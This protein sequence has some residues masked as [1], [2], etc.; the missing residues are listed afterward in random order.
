MLSYLTRLSCLTLLTLLLCRAMPP[1]AAADSEPSGAAPDGRPRLAL[2][3]GGGGTRGAAHVGVLRVLEEEGIHVDCLAGTSIGSIVGGMYAAGVSLDRIQRLAESKAIFHA[4]NTVP[5]PLR[6]A[7]IPIT[8]IPRLFGIHPYVGL[9]RG[10]KF[11]NFLD[12]NLPRDRRN[13][14][15]TRIPFRAVATD[16]LTGDPYVISKG[17]LGRAMQASAAIPWLRKPVLLDG[18]VLNDGVLAANLPVEQ[19]RAMGADAVICVD[20]D[21]PLKPATEKEFRSIKFLENRTATMI[22]TKLDD[23]YRK[24]ADLVIQPDVADIPVLSARRSDVQSAVAAGEKAAR[25]ALPA[26][27][28]LVLERKR[29]PAQELSAPR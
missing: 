25:E 21:G 26:I 20:V 6:V 7:I 24:L 12:R 5:I 17:P 18:A 27:R 3:L 28:K 19:A 2:A 1:C 23:H 16:M 13:V 29:R 15:E 8:M 11:A 10:K 14:E 4:Y 22:M 9:Y